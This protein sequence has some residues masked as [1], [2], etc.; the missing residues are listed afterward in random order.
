MD[1][2]ERNED[3]SDSVEITTE[4][5]ESAALP[6]LVQNATQSQASKNNATIINNKIKNIILITIT[7][8]NLQ[9]HCCSYF[10]WKL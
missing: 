6:K 3:A 4:P 1:H 2:L 7:H 9:I 8:Q 5:P 10:D